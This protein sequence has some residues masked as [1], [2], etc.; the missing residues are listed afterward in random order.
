MSR[1]T[2]TSGRV[3]GGTDRAWADCWPTHR[4]CFNVVVVDGY[5]RIS[6]NR[7][8]LGAILG[9]LNS[10]GVT[11][12]CPAL[13]GW[14]TV[15]Q[16]SC[17][18]RGGRSHRRGGALSKRATWPRLRRSAGRWRVLG[19]STSDGEDRNK[20]VAGTRR[21]IAK[22]TA[23]QEREERAGREGGP[24][25]NDDA[26]PFAAL[27][28]RSRREPARPGQRRARPRP[29]GLPR[30]A[31]V[32]TTGPRWRWR[33]RAMLDHDVRGKDNLVGDAAAAQ[34]G[35]ADNGTDRSEVT[36]RRRWRRPTE[37]RARRRLDSGAEGA[38]GENTP[39]RVDAG[40]A[41]PYGHEERR[42]G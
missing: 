4:P 15:R 1:P 6:P 10:A 16:D 42:I 5:G 31:P 33:E 36:E 22:R 18:P 28:G 30:L 37:P 26:G 9:H 40:E 34:V 11:T 8:E 17:E 32:P 19:V 29:A 3:S 23:Y 12:V 20:G 41:L 14:T 24:S 21:P 13:I 39:G 27:R 2:P 38:G 25:E 7:H 35:R